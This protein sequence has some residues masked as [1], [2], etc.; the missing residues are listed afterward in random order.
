MIFYLKMPVIL[1]GLNL[2]RLRDEK[3]EEETGENITGDIDFLL[4]KVLPLVK[5]DN[6]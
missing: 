4:E 3:I 6:S 5:S 1:N 2:K